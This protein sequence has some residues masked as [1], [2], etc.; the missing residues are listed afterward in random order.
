MIS[1]RQKLA[2]SDRGLEPQRPRSGGRTRVRVRTLVLIRWLAITG[3]LI[4][5]L[6]VSVLVGGSL[7]MV[8]ALIALG[9]SALLNLGIGMRWDLNGWHNELEATSFL[10]FDI[11]QLSVLLFLTGGL[12]NPFAVL[13][14]APVTI[15]ATILSLVSTL[16]LGVLAFGCGLV[17][18]FFHLPLPWPFG[19]F[20]LPEGY[21]SAILLALTVC[22]TFLLFNAWRVAQESRRMADALSATQLALAREQEMSSLGGLAANAAHALGT[23]LGT[24]A[25]VVKE[26][27]NNSPADADLAEDLQLLQEQTERCRD[28]LAGLSKQGFAEEDSRFFLQTLAVI[29]M[30]ASEPYQSGDVE[31]VCLELPK[32]PDDPAPLIQRSAELLQGLSN[33]IE[34]AVDFAETRVVI[35]ADWDDQEVRL[36]IR[37]DGPG[38]SANMFAMLG[39]PYVSTRRHRGGM[40]LGVFISKTLLERTGANI[41]FDNQRNSQ[42]AVVTIAWPRAEIEAI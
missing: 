3:Q 7:P 29:A 22:M 16:G 4:S 36:F 37:D 39:D 15:S 42:G 17:L 26:L 10:A 19:V 18:M 41:R 28:I 8:P 1:L 24:I 5:L 11:V 34:N 9:C 14:V 6:V 27:Q 32:D 40:G 23:P 12:E 13:L 35:E 33:L 25:L 20:S 2:N 38:F 31:I 30:S 21:V